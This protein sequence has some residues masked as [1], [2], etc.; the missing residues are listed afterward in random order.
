M[1][2]LQQQPDANVHLLTEQAANVIKEAVGTGAQQA[3]AKSGELKGEA[4]EYAGKGKG[5]AEEALGEAKG[6]TKEAAGEIEGKAK[7]A[8]HSL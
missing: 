3:K 7:E 1:N 8:K 5:K 2:S 4:A 6:K